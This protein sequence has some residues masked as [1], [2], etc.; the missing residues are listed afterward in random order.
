MHYENVMRPVGEEE[1]ARR[2][3]PEDHAEDQDASLSSG[4]KEK[5]GDVEDDVMV[6]RRTV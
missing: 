5:G 6:S 2:S 4:D 3:W 1:D